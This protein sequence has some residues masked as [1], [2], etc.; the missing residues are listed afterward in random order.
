MKG[1]SLPINM[2]VIIAISVIVL[3]AIAAF[4]M[5]GFI[6]G[7]TTISDQSALSSGCG[8]WKN[9]GCAPNENFK[10]VGYDWNLDNQTDYLSDACFRVLG[11]SSRAINSTCH[12]Y[13]CKGY[14]AET[15]G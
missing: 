10:I 6:G 14:H 12:D 1:I 4:F 11:D 13:C 15:G 3:L 9:R 2:I 8:T 7:S 5:G